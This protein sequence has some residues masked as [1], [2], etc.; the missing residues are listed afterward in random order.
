NVHEAHE[1]VDALSKVVK[2]NFGDSVELFVHTDGCL[3]FSCKICSKFDCNV[4]Q[5]PFERKIN[6]TIENISKNIKHRID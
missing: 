1:E 4:R 5:H 2:D 3:N 6:W